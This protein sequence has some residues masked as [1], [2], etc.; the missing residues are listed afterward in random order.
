MRPRTSAVERGGTSSVMTQASNASDGRCNAWWTIS[1]ATGLTES[2]V[3]LHIRGE[4]AARVLSHAER[5]KANRPAHPILRLASI[6]KSPP[7]SVSRAIF[8]GAVA[9]A[10][11][12]NPSRADVCNLYIMRTRSLIY[13]ALSCA[14]AASAMAVP[15]SHAVAVEG[16]VQ[17]V[18]E[19]VP[20]AEIVSSLRGGLKRDIEETPEPVSDFEVLSG[21]QG[22]LKR[23]VEESPEPVPD[24]EVL[25]GLKGGL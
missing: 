3:R 24:F 10:A 17:E 15:A 2:R 9:A 25:N 23:D 19:A 1:S 21:L 4:S 20:D 6:T 16:A 22:G 5:L 14:V 13:A 18:P 12:A 7:K 8:P 11:V